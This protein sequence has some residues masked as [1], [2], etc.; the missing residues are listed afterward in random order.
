L[1]FWDGTQWVSETPPPERRSTRWRDLAA[2][3]TMIIVSG[4]LMLPF[5][6]TFAS[7]VPAPSLSL[8]PADGPA[9][10]SV[11]IKGAGFTGKRVQITWDGSMSDLPTAPVNGRGVFKVTIKVPGKA[12]GPHTL[13]AVAFEKNATAEGV[14]LAS[15][16]FTLA[17][18]PDPTPAPTA[19]PTPTPAPTAR[20]TATPAPTAAPTATPDPTAAPTAAPTPTPAPTAGP[21]ATPA[22]TA[23]PTATP[24]AAPTAGPTPTP[25]PLPTA[26]P[27][28]TP[29]PTAGP[30]PTPLPTAIPTAIPTATP[31]PTA[32]PTQ[33]AGSKAVI[34][35]SIPALKTALADNTVDE[36][37][38]ANGT[39][40]LSPSHRFLADSLW[41]GGNAYANRTRPITVRA[42]T[43]G[44][45]T[46]DGGGATG[47]AALSFEDGA[48]DQTWDG[49][50]FANMVANESGIIEFGGY[51]P[52]RTVHHLTIRNIRILGTC[53]GN[54]TTSS[55]NTTEHAIYFAHA[56]GVGPHDLLAEDIS[57]DGSGFLASA[58]H[59]DHGDALNPPAWNVTVRRLHV[60][61]TQQAIIL[62]EPAFRNWTIDTADISGA[63]A[64][65]VRYEAIGGTGITFS[66]ITSTG[67]GVRGFYSSQ[68]TAPA[69]VTFV[70]DSLR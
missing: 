20:P 68:G 30:T 5:T 39:Y 43:I 4:A 16:V 33:P 35:A 8:S 12:A 47:Y 10:T 50:T 19:A 31:A 6:A 58:I 45:V 27:T 57:V 61:K 55:G 42:A 1:A 67:S 49:F 54:A 62:W 15:T 59:G 23:G 28:P 60:V 38:V 34:V 32:A 22:P 24:T 21:T 36:I 7:D 52:R 70:N 65:A 66:N 46:F 14:P 51:L 56:V 53:R 37:I 63:L 69:N 41:I 25:T 13:A 48:H 3:A 2:T 29:L 40:H 11:T 17:T 9:G 44:G 64:Y 26:G 18:P